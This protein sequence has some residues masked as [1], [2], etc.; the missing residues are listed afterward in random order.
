MKTLKK[1]AEEMIITREYSNT[2]DQRRIKSLEQ[3][4]IKLAQQIDILIHNS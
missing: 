3:I 1:Q 4:V 2:D